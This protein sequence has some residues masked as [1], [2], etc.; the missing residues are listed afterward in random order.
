MASFQYTIIDKY[1]K[2]KK[3]TMEAVGKDKVSAIL[4]AEGNIPIRITEQNMFTKDINIGFGNRVG[5]RE[6]GIFCR[7]FY[8]ILYAGISIIPALNMVGNQTENR[9]LRKALKEVQMSVEKGDTLASAMKGQ[10]EVFPNILIS[11]I[12]AGEASGNLD[13]SFER[14]ASHF[15][16][17]A[18][19]KGI[20]KKAMIY[21]SFVGVIA[22]VVVIVMLVGVIPQFTVMFSEMNIEMPG[23][24]KFIINMS[25]FLL[26]NG[27]YIGIVAVIAITALRIFLKSDLGQEVLGRIGLKVPVVN[28]L[29]IKTAS[30]R[31]GKTLATLLA[32]GIPLIDAIEITAKVTDN[33]IIKNALLKAKDDVERGVPLSQPLESSGLFPPMVYQMIRIGEETGQIENMLEKIAVYYEEEVENA[34]QALIAVIEPLMI[35]TLAV[36]V[37]FILVAIFGPMMSIY[38]GVESL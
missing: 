27:F 37:G 2:E 31:L 3:G 6:L 4:R 20:M 1:G 26:K 5:L 23:L 29:I 22:V 21:P 14:M 9:A 24:T 10:S 13:V 36:F 17:E 19:L 7:Q 33:V 8:S 38:D 28:K 34:S 32:A 16:K 18:K 15:E 12:E 11:M 25:D 35:V 30:A